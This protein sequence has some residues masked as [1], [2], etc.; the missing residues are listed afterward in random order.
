[1]SEFQ[2]ILTIVAL[3]IFVIFFK[4]LFSGNH[5]KR[6]VDFE[7]KLPQESIGGVSRP[8]KIFKEQKSDMKEKSRVEELLGMAAKSIEDGDNIE[9]K[10]ALEALL[11]LE[12]EN[13]EA[14]RMLG[15]VFMNMNNYVDA[16]ETYLK[17][18]RLDENDDL[19]QNLL[20]N[21]L[22]KLG[23]DKEALEHHK[24]AI[25]LDPN[26]AAYHYNFANTLYE[27]G[28]K[29]EALQAYKKALELEPT[30]QDAQKMIKEL[31]DVQN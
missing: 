21:T 23:E 1:M 13:K 11:I 7:S 4:Q 18:L 17:V 16:K 28:K 10:K 25:E 3:S 2:L 9:A 6:G 14:L 8:D 26:Y 22:H 30:L 5:P 19:S 12:P 31:E 20:A 15:V 29:E 27:A 24:R